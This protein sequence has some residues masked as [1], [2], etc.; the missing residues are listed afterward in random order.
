[1][2]HRALSGSRTSAFQ[3]H[4]QHKDKN[5]PQSTELQTA[6]T[7]YAGMHI[8]ESHRNLQTLDLTDAMS[9]IEMS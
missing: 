6:F 9:V 5:N 3:S 4:K 2:T 1:V 8:K 7:N